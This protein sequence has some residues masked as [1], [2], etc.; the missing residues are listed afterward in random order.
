MTKLSIITINFNNTVGLEKT[1]ESVVSQTYSSF[2]FIVIDGAS[3]DSSIDIITKYSEQITYWVSEKDTG[4]YNAMNKGIEKATGEYCLFLNSGDYLVSN[5]I[6]QEIFKN[7]FDQ[8]LIAFDVFYQFSNG[9][10]ELKTQ[11]N[12]VNFFFMMRSSLFHPSTLIKRILFSEFGVYNENLKIASDYDFFLRISIIEQAAYK[13]FPIPITVFDTGGISSRNEMLNV[14]YRERKLIQ[15]K[16]FTQ[17]IID[18]AEV[19]DKILLSDSYRFISILKKRKIF[20]L[21]LMF[22]FKI[23]IGIKRMFN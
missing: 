14:I 10:R 7:D 19:H 18:A 2:E 4:I 5:N 20:Y 3:S 22:V 23:A 11:P 1:I 13:Y 17:K 21:P 8:D 12:E 9:K 15:Q 6:L 16:Y